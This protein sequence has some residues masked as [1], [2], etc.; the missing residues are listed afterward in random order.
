MLL[1]VGV[2]TVN[3]SK[4]YASFGVAT[5]CSWNSGTNTMGFTAV[6]G[7]QILLTGLPGGDIT[8]YTTFH[9]TLS[10]MTD[11]I[12]SVRLRIKDKSDNYADVN[13]LTGENNIDLAALS[14]SNPTCDFTNI[15]DLT[16][17]SPT[18]AA[19]GKVV[20]GE[21]PASVVITD[22]YMEKPDVPSI[23]T[24]ILLTGG[25]FSECFVPGTYY[26]EMNGWQNFTVYENPTGIAF[27]ENSTM[28]FDMPEQSN[29][30]Q[31]R[32]VFTYDD[33]STS[34]IWWCTGIGSS[35]DDPAIQWNHKLDNSTFWLKKGLGTNFDSKKDLKITKVTVNNQNFTGGIYKINGGTICG[36]TMTIK[37]QGQ[38][39]DPTVFGAYGG[40]FRATAGLTNI[41]KMENFEVGDNQKIVIKFSEPVPSKGNWN[42]NNNSG[43]RSLSGK[44]EYEFAL[45]GKAISDFTIF[46]F[47][48]NPDPIKIS[49]VYFYKTVIEA[50][51]IIEAPSSTRDLNGMTGKGEIRWSLSYPIEMGPAIGIGGDL[52]TDNNSVDI[53]SYDYLHFY[54][55]SVETGKKLSARVFVSE[56]E[57]NDNAKRHCLYLRPIADAANPSTNWEEVYYITEPGTYVA[58]I[59]DYPLLRGIKGGNGWGGDESTG[60]ITIPQAYLSSGDPVDYIPSGKYTLVG[61]GVASASLTTALADANATFYDATGVTG[62][63]VDL[64]SAANPNALFKANA[65]VLANTNNVI[66]NGTCDNL[67]LTDNHPFQAPADFTATAASYSTTINTTAQCGTLCLPFD[68]TIPDGVT[69]YTLSYVSG[70]DAAT[71]T[72]VETTIPA[73]TP[74]LLNGSGAAT[75]TGSGAVDADA[76]N[77]SGA[78]TGVFANT[79]VPLNSYVL[80]NGASGIGFYKVASDITAKPFRAYLTGEF[81]GSK[82]F[83]SFNFDDATGVNSLSSMDGAESSKFNVQSSKIYN[84]AGQRM[85]KLQKGVNI[86]NGKKV[87][88][89]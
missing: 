64:T 48:E 50:S 11:N 51:E 73:N 7:W 9:A 23:K 42:I 59:S 22:A 75:F 47:D 54:V 52:D 28:V 24:P 60:K 41:F 3:A 49:E 6:N 14:A 12:E 25:K 29:N 35:A 63:G 15:N 88:V 38:W 21:H 53:S 34:E 80:Q 57:R 2:G 65:G 83:L 81:A 10:D 68:A 71:L 87:L 27:D 67:V 8:A 26:I 61:E 78:L 86:V 89:K 31:V 55:T 69:A 5:G 85:S 62:T 82:E 76:T 30:E 79:A 17:W 4:T 1:I 43:F 74:V 77:V 56:E 39:Y 33:A 18:S 19:A 32:V 44:T 37:K 70:N 46:N 20:D 72:P 13:L 84:L 66:V 16:I 40:E 36:E 58:K 45:D